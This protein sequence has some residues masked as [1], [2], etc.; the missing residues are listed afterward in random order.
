VL[1]GRAEPPSLRS[2]CHWHAAAAAGPGAA[3]GPVVPGP[4]TTVTRLENRLELEPLIMT[5]QA[6]QVAAAGAAAAAG[7]D[8]DSESH[9]HWQL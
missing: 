7:A 5:P 2:S 1:A 8:S 4:G 3:G 6:A 9:Y